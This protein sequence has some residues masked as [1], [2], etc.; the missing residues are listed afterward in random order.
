MKSHTHLEFWNVDGT[1]LDASDAN[2]APFSLKR[3]EQ[4]II[5]DRPY[6]V[7]EIIDSEPRED[8][9]RIYYRRIV[10]VR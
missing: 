6:E 9:G 8:D 1:I 5:G 3:G 4:I 2:A 10:R 7:V